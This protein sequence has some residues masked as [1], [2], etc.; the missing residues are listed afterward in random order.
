MAEQIQ[1]AFE[2][3][4]HNLKNAGGR[5]WDDVYKVTTYNVDLDGDIVALLI[6]NLKKFCPNHKPC[7]TALGVARLAS[8]EMKVEIDVVAQIPKESA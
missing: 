6:K 8:P 1:Q 4:Q 2:N 7:W 3:V 5:G